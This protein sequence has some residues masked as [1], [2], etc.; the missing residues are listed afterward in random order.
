MKQNVILTLFIGVI[1]LQAQTA[2]EIEAILAR[3]APYQYGSDPAASVDLDEM[4]GRL[5]GSAEKR[6]MAETLLLKFVQSSATPAGKEFAFRQLSLVGSN[7]S[8]PVL[9]PLLMRGDT[10]EMARY[11][12]A[13]IP[14]PSV[15]EALIQALGR[16][17]SDRARIGLVNS[18]GKRGV[19]K[20]VAPIAALLSNSNTEVIAAAAAALAA[21]ADRPSLDALGAARRSVGAPV[22]GVVSE[23]YLVCADH[24]A[25]RG[26]KATAIKV[27]QEMIAAAE[28]A[29]L[30]TRALKSFAAA[31]ANAAT[32]ALIAELRSNSPERQV[33][34]IRLMAG[35]PGAAISKE[36]IGEYPKLTAVSQVHVLTAMAL[37]ADASAKPTV[38]AAIKS[39]ERAVRTAALAAVGSL[40]DASNV[41][42][43]AEAAAAGEEPEA[44]A[45]RRS[46]YTLRGPE[47]DP[48]IIAAL[49]STNGKVKAELI[50]AAGE[51]AAVSTADALVQA[52]HETDPDVRRE[53]LRAVRNVGGAAQT[54][55]L[56]S[57]LLA[58]N[59][60]IERREATQTLAAVVRRAQ[61]SPVAAVISA[62]KA[63]SPREVKVSLLDVM[64]QSSSSEALPVLRETLKDTD[65]EMVRAAILALTAWD[66]STPL[67]D[68][69]NVAKTSQ[70]PTA[71][72][73]TPPPAQPGAGAGRGGRGGGG[74][75]AGAGRG[76]PPT[77]NIQIL[78]LRGVLRLMILQ[79]DR[80]PAETGR[81]L[82]E[83]MS[84]SSQLPE[85]RNVL[86][87]LPYFPSK[88]SLEVAQAAARDD[89]VANEAKVA[90][91]QVTEGMK[92][93]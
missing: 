64:G 4:M 35:I 39:S 24:Y 81:L 21:I 9:A 80:T 45:A 71:E 1:S 11:A 62:Y 6:R 10:V 57:M 86:G 77:N 8:I 48:A 28:P 53:A 25:Q 40:G 73:L 14:G 41:R 34:A 33:F 56:L 37:R 58:A 15:D 55:A 26:D 78:A 16:S 29:P 63:A 72:M 43:L 7:A 5:S 47:I 27:Y 17:P 38:L 70:R 69:L 90:V 42:M 61:P 13:A 49:S 68:L 46:L 88:E 66:N 30:R 79:S 32:P 59:S 89:A 84:L 51:R 87:L 60:A 67:P 93:R 74:G 50:M 52:A 22:R 44:S 23:G 31:D 92:A 82:A 83:V 18:L 36:L 91:D 76:A 20:A 12:L 2:A 3:I 19:T 75:G 54:P 65:P 85:K